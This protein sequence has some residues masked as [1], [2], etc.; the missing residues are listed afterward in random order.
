MKESRLSRWEKMVLVPTFLAG[1]NQKR[2]ETVSKLQVEALEESEH[3][4]TKLTS[5]GITQACRELI[6]DIK[7]GVPT[8]HCIMHAF[9]TDHMS[10]KIE[11][12]LDIVYDKDQPK[13]EI[14]DD[15]CN[16]LAIASALGV[17]V[18]PNASSVAPQL[19]RY[20][21]QMLIEGFT[22]PDGD[23][24]RKRLK[25]TRSLADR[26]DNPDIL[27]KLDP[28]E[29]ISPADLLLITDAISREMD[30][31]TG[32]RTIVDGIKQAI[33]E[34]SALLDQSKRNENDVQACLTANPVLFGPDYKQIIPKHRF[35]AEFELDY[36]LVRHSGIIDLVEIESPSLTLFNRKGDP[37]SHL[38]HAEQQVLD[39]LSWAE[40]NNAY[41]Q[42]AL[43]GISAPI[44]FVVIGRSHALTQ[45]E[46]AKLRSRNSLFNGKLQVLTYDDLLERSRQIL[47]AISS[48]GASKRES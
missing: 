25:L 34:L 3:E 2:L 4:E 12:V 9:D 40:S 13:E 14:E 41:A 11:H 47:R 24:G 16:T 28:T 15:I 37:S 6:F 42:K 27:H 1:D 38:I 8:F 43:P 17:P 46:T 36:A 7:E 48:A 19:A 35:G 29:S 30:E 18:F 44:G 26:L 32:V 10:I 39:W 22:A 21:R 23:G 31:L 20:H 5:L 45:N 33:A